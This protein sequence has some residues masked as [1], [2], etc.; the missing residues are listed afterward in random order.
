[1]PGEPLRDAQ[2]VEL[3][4]LLPDGPSTRRVHAEA[5]VVRTD[6]EGLVG[7]T[8]T[9][10]S[11]TDKTFLRGSVLQR[12]M[13]QMHSIGEYPAFRGLA[14]LELLELASVTHELVL[15]EGQHA[16]RY[17]DEAT[18]VFLVKRGAVRLLAPGE[19]NDPASQTVETARAGQ[20]FGEASALLGLPHNLDVVAAEL[21]ELLLV[22]HSAL[23]HLRDHNPHL[24]LILYEIFAA[25]MGRRLRRL[26][27]RLVSPLS[28]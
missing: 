16:A 1:M 26:T 18:S 8:F 13:A 9:R 7:L 23:I 11:S 3:D 28:S 17:G 22:P 12:A 27:G 14:D 4:I 19:A 21:T 20:V 2:E 5:T 24:A 6:E 15:E 10:L 25:F